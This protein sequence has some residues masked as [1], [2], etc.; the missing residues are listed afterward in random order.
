MASSMQAEVGGSQPDPYNVN[1]ED[2]GTK[3][4]VVSYF[5]LISLSLHNQSVRAVS[6]MPAIINRKPV[7]KLPK[8][9]GILGSRSGQIIIRHTTIKQIE[10][11]LFLLV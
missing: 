2:E 3:A 8:I 9:G 4:P 6:S 7:S 11:Y 1:E 10:Y 5:I